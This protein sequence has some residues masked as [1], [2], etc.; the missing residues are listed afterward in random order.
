MNIAAQRKSDFVELDKPAAQ[1]GHT[2]Q[3]VDQLTPNFIG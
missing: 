3:G 2:C 1:P